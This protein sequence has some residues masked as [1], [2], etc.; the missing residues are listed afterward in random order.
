MQKNILDRLLKRG[1]IR[2]RDLDIERIKSMIGFSEEN[3]DFIKK[4]PVNQ[5]SSGVIFRE[6]YE[7]IRQLGDVKWWL[8]GYEPR[9]HEVCLDLLEELEIKNKIKL[10]SLDRFKKIRHDLNYRG[11]RISVEQAKEIL[12]FWEDCASEIIKI[13]KEEIDEK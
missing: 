1:L 8:V 13:L 11:N 5:E 2:K 7:S 9:T 4:L 12:E 6:M 10:N 3:V